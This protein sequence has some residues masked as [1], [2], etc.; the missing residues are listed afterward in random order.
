MLRLTYYKARSTGWRSF[1]TPGE[2]NH[3]LAAPKTILIVKW[4]L[5]PAGLIWHVDIYIQIDVFHAA[6]GGSMIAAGFPAA[7]PQLYILDIRK[8]KAPPLGQPPLA[9]AA[10]LVD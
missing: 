8:T 4:T 1:R 5:P 2:P 6:L 7:C 3:F 9:G 10:K